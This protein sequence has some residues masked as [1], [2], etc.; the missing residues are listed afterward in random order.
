MKKILN[1]YLF[2]SFLI[3]VLIIFCINYNNRRG[4]RETGDI[5]DIHF[6]QNKDDTNFKICDSTIVPQYF[7]VGTEYVGGARAIKNEIFS[8]IE[9]NNTRFLNN[10]GIITFRFLVNCKGEIG[11]FRVFQV[12]ENQKETNFSLESLTKLEE[13]IKKL[14]KWEL[15]AYK[16]NIYDSYYIVRCIIKDGL[17]TDI[18]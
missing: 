17:I 13:V 6:D 10:S 4:F 9:I 11:R 2:I 14:S 3:T 18:F 8:K 5:G 15:K 16:N 7:S 12:D 1:W